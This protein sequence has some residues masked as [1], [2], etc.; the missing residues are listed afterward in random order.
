MIDCC[1]TKIFFICI[2]NI[3]LMLKILLW[4]R[5]VLKYKICCSRRWI[6]RSRCSTLETIYR[7]FGSLLFALQKRKKEILQQ[8]LLFE[9]KKRVTRLSKRKSKSFPRHRATTNYIKTLSGCRTQSDNVKTVLSHPTSL[10]R[11]F[12]GQY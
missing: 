11:R 6:R 3:K 12:S 1:C 7:N 5:F 9:L 10:L 8:K 2:M 4:T